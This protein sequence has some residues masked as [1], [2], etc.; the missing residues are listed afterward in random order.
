MCRA[1]QRQILIGHAMTI[2][3]HTPAPLR[4]VIFSAA[5]N[6]PLA[7]CAGDNSA[8]YERTPRWRCIITSNGEQTV[9][10]VRSSS[11]DAA[12]AIVLAAYPGTSVWCHLTVRRS[13][14]V[15]VR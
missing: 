3:P 2:F 1:G 14:H 5:L 9:R 13:Q 15:F 6:L 11:A 10:I 7:V 4:A 12:R 8:F